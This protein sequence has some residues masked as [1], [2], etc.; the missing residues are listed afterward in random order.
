MLGNFALRTAARLATGVRTYIVPS[1]KI[2]VVPVYEQT[3]RLIPRGSNPLDVQTQKMFARYDPDGSK[4]KMF[5]KKNPMCP[6]AG[7][8]LRVVKKD[9]STFVGMLLA[10]NRNQ[11][12]TTIL[13][14]TKI[15]SI[16]VE[17]RFQIYNPDIARIELLKVPTMRWPKEKYYF[18]RGTKNHDAGDLDG[19]VR[20]QRRAQMGRK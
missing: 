20:R 4:R 11:L 14:R 13:L 2:N 3:P 16:G 6:R 9:K 7:D 17:N 18:V 12:A 8:V 19:F 5:S 1:R 15:G 10:L